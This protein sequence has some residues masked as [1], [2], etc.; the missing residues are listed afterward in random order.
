MARKSRENVRIAARSAI[1]IKAS[2][3][4][5]K[6]VGRSD[7]VCRRHSLS[8]RYIASRIGAFPRSYEKDPA[9]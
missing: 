1:V 2:R 9:C 6:A 5:F 7:A 4:W 8:F 3:G